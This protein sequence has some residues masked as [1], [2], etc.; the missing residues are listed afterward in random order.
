M[1]M[2]GWFAQLPASLR[3]LIYSLILFS[4]IA[5]M[6][7]LA[8]RARQATASAATDRIAIIKERIEFTRG[9]LFAVLLLVLHN[10]GLFVWFSTAKSA[11]QETALAVIWTGGNVLW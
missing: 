7:W 5:L 10:V 4:A 6:T 9:G 8:L 11:F 3:Y 1:S 2:E